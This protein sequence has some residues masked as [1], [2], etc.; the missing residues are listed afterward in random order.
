MAKPLDMQQVAEIRAA[1]EL[2]E[3]VRP[4]GRKLGV[5]KDTVSK[6]FNQDEDLRP[7]DEE[8]FRTLVDQAKEHQVNEWI[9]VG[10]L[11]RRKAVQGLAN[12]EVGNARDFKDLITAGAIQLTRWPS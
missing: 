9:A 11:A 7:E 8:A 6:Y 2:G 3:G 5:H 12:V 4:T 1:K 10:A